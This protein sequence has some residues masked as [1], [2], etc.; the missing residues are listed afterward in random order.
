MVIVHSY[1]S[2]PEGRSCVFFGQKDNYVKFNIVQ[3]SAS[4]LARWHEQPHDERQWS[5]KR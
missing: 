5:N 3:T 1:V 2:L 4:P